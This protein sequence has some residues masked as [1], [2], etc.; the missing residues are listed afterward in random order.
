MLSSASGVLEQ[1][2]LEVRLEVRLRPAVVVYPFVTLIRRSATWETCVSRILSAAPEDVN[3]GDDVDVDQ[4]RGDTAAPTVTNAPKI[5]ATKVEEDKQGIMTAHVLDAGTEEGVT[6]VMDVR[7]DSVGNVHRQ[8][9][10][11]LTIH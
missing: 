1:V 7:T 6:S 8:H 9:S 5:S 11:L 3:G 2:R 10:T 4:R